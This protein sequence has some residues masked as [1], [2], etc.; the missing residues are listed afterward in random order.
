[1]PYE[2]LLHAEFG[3]EVDKLNRD[4]QI[5]I[6]EYMNTLKQEGHQLG[7]PYADTLNGSSF[8]NMKEL[9]LKVNKVQW[10]VA[11]A[12]DKKQRAVLLAVTSK[13][14][15]NSRLVYERLIATADARFK[16]HQAALKHEE[17]TAKAKRKR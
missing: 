11:F 3:P 17:A 8:P 10:R 14:G 15:Q 1:M 12:F 9:R 13:G 2:V 6:A 5:A 16:A 7:R 4:V